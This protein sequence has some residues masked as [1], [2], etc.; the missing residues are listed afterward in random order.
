VLLAVVNDVLDFSK[1]ESG[2]LHVERREFSLH[3]LL[4]HVID[5]VGDSA[6]RKGLELTLIVQDSVPDEVVG[7][8]QGLRQ[9]LLNLLS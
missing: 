4:H 3:D 9:V 7:D 5:I 2:K 6:D 1:I 8:A